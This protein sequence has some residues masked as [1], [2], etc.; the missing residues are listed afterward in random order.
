MFQIFIKIFGI[1]TLLTFFVACSVELDM[2]DEKP[3]EVQQVPPE[4]ILGIN[5]VLKRWR[6][7]FEIGDIDTYIDTYWSEGFRYVSD[8]GTEGDKTDDIEFDDIREE[9]DS[10]TKVFSQFQDIKIELTMPPVI[11]INEEYTQAEVRNHYQIQGYVADGEA[12]EG[13]YTGWF[14][15]G[16]NVYMFEKR[17]GEWR[18]TE[19]HDE[20]LHAEE[21]QI[22]NNQL[23]PIVWSTLK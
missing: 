3:V 14:A 17:D 18:I 20:A 6:E 11:T 21:I 10:A 23:L 2:V 8:M 22:E 19:W 16:D 13:E 5:D 15:E 7:G 12:F 9:R 4:D 1:L